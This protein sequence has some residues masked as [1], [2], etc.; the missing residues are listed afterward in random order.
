[1][2]TILLIDDHPDVLTVMSRLLAIHGHC[3]EV[4]ASVEI[5]MDSLDQHLPDVII[6]DERLP[7][8]SGLDLFR[9]IR[10]NERTAALPVIIMSASETRS[11]EAIKAGAADFWLKGTDWILD[12]MANLNQRIARSPRAESLH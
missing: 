10:R 12:R 11:E 4:C 2:A 8:M 3:V 1:M 6:T 7:G 9:M 5:A